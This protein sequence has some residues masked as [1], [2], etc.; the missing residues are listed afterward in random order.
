[1]K[2]EYLYVCDGQVPD[3]KKT[4]CHYNGTG[5]CRH[6]TD[7]SHALYPDS[8]E[9]EWKKTEGKKVTYCQAVL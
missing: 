4:H 3:C 1:M 7:K 8:T 9:W 6:T 2:Y 5:R